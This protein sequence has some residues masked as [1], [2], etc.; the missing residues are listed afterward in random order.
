MKR[1]E[2]GGGRETAAAAKL[3]GKPQ[4]YWSSA[5]GLEIRRLTSV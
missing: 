4:D 5:V 2:R 3:A 1:D